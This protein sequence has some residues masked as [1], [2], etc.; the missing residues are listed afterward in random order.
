MKVHLIDTHLL[1]LRSRSSVKV[2]YQ[3]LYL[4]KMAVEGISISV[5]QT[6][7]VLPCLLYH[8]YFDQRIY[9]EPQ[10]KHRTKKY[11]LNSQWNCLDV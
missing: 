3:N 7:L 6:H 11:I 2:K 4:E 9:T 5:S 8:L 1:V 10:K